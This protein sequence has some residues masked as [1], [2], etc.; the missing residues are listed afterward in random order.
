MTYE[1][2]AIETYKS[3][4]CD[5]VDVITMQDHINSTSDDSCCA[6]F[7]DYSREVLHHFIEKC[8]DICRNENGNLYYHITNHI[9]TLDSTV[10]LPMCSKKR[11]EMVG[12]CDSVSM[13]VQ[14][15]KCYKIEF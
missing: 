10:N 9:I 6:S 8:A 7:C 3:W 14:V 2:K 11:T 13:Y 15:S 12:A 1:R 5:T 4:I